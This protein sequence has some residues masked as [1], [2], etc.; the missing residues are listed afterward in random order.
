[1]G[2]WLWQYSSE[3]QFQW[4]AVIRSKFGQPGNFWTAANVKHSPLRSPWKRIV[5]VLPP[6]LPFTKLSL[7]CGSSI[8]FWIDPWI[9]S[10]SLDSRFP[11]LFNSMLKDSFTL[12]SSLFLLTGTSIFLETLLNLK[13]K[14]LRIFLTSSISFSLLPLVLTPEYGPFPLPVRYLHC[15]LI[16]FCHLF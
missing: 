7:G 15:V 16:F 14:R 2:K 1:M 12:V 13:F 11:R 6:F 5:Q 10:T 9:F 8:R 4:A 3:H